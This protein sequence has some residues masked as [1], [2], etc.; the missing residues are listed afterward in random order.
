MTQGIAVL[1]AVSLS[2]ACG[3]GVRRTAG[4]FLASKLCLRTLGSGS[5]LRCVSSFTSVRLGLDRNQ[6]VCG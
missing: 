4:G 1:P 2:H 3:R 5:D 6:Q